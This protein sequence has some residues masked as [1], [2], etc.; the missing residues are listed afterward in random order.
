MKK[1]SLSSLI[2]YL[3]PPI[4]N[5]YKGGLIIL[6]GIATLILDTTP[7]ILLVCLILG[8]YEILPDAAKIIRFLGDINYLK[9]RKEMN[10]ILEDFA[11]AESFMNGNV[12]VGKSY[13]FGKKS[14][15]VI[16]YADIDRAH[17]FIRKNN[18]YRVK[19]FIEIFTFDD[20][21]IKLCKV[22]S[23]DKNIEACEKIMHI[24]K[25]R[26]PKAD[27]MYK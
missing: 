2:S 16:K 21:K 5:F 17:H 19:R 4:D 25:E 13:I 7:W 10:S 14:G 3:F 6:I 15:A 9:T 12:R 18:S 24:I 23:N 26:N 8:I 11:E 1:A 20:T 27:V 22:S